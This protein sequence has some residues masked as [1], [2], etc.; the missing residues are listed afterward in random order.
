MTS[1]C[2]VCE[3][4]LDVDWIEVTVCGDPEPSYIPGQRRCP[5]RCDPRVARL[6]T[7]KD[8]WDHQTGKCV[9]LG[10]AEEIKTIVGDPS[11]TLESVMRD[12]DPIWRRE[13]LY[14]ICCEAD[15]LDALARRV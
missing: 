14:R 9:G 8:V 12:P 11:A 13:A 2:L 10:L 7:R 5:N 6:F 4:E 3:T 15:R 1:V